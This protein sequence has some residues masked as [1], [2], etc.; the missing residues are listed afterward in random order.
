MENRPGNGS[1]TGKLP[2]NDHGNRFQ[3][4]LLFLSFIRAINKSCKFHLGTELA[5][6]GGKF[7]D[8]I[9]VKNYGQPNEKKSF[10][11]LQAK[12]KQDEK[13]NSIKA[14]DLLNDN[15]D[16]F[17]LTKYFH[18][19]RDNIITAKE[20]P[21]TQDTV[22]CVICT[23][24]DFD[25]EDI[26]NYGMKLVILSED[27]LN[28]LPREL[29]TFNP[30]ERSIVKED[31]VKP[32]D[33]SKVKEKYYKVANFFLQCATNPEYDPSKQQDVI[34]SYKKICDT[35]GANE[36]IID[37]DPT[38]DGKMKFS[39][40]FINNVLKGEAKELRTVIDRK[41]RNGS[42][43]QIGESWKQWKFPCNPIDF[44]QKMPKCYRLEPIRWLEMYYL[45][46]VLRDC[47][48]NQKKSLDQQGDALKYYQA[49]LVDEKVIDLNTKTFYQDFISG[50]KNLSEAAKELRSIFASRLL[51]D[52]IFTFENA[53]TFFTPIARKSQPIGNEYGFWYR[54]RNLRESLGQVYEI[55]CQQ[56]RPPRP[57]E[58]QKTLKGSTTETLD[59]LANVLC[60][61]SNNRERKL[62]NQDDNFKSYHAALVNEKVLDT[63]TKRFHKDFLNDIELSKEARKL[64]SMIISRLLQSWKFTFSD[65]STFKN[66]KNS[67]RESIAQKKLDDDVTEIERF[68][69]EK[70][71]FAA[72]T[73]NEE[74]LIT[75]LNDEVGKNSK[76]Q[77]HDTDFQLPYILCQ[78]V[79]WFKRT[80]NVWLTGEE[81]EKII[82]DKTEQKLDSIRTTALTMHY[83]DE[84]KAFLSFNNEEIKK[85]S[86]ELKT[87]L[88]DR[89]N[90]EKL[91]LVNIKSSSPIFTA[92][93][94]IQVIGCISTDDKLKYYKFD[95]SYLVTSSRR[96]LEG[97][98]KEWIKKTLLSPGNP[99]QLLIVVNDNDVP[100][101]LVGSGLESNA[102]FS[103]SNESESLKGKKVI[104]IGKEKT[105]LTLLLY[106][107]NITFEQWSEDAK[108][109][110]LSKTISFQ[111]SEVTVRD[112]IGD[113]QPNEILD[114]ESINQLLTT[115]GE[116]SMAIPPYVTSKFEKSLYIKRK[117]TF[118]FDFNN[119]F[120]KEMAEDLNG[121][122]TAKKKKQCQINR[123]TGTI[124]WI[125][126]VNEEVKDE[127]WRNILKKRNEKREPLSE[128]N[129]INEENWETRAVIIKGVAGTGKSTVLFHFYDE[130]KKK[131]PN[132]WAIRIDLKDHFDALK[133][134][135]THS[136]NLSDA[137][138]FFLHLPNVVDN[139]SPFARSLLRRRLETGDRIVLMLDG[140]DEIDSDCK[141]IAIQLMKALIGNRKKE[142][143][144]LRL[145]I[146]TRPDVADNLQLQLG[147]LAYTLVNFSAENQT[148]YLTSFWTKNVVPINIQENE[149]I[150][151]IAKLLV[152]R[153]SEDL[154]DDEK[155]FI[156][157]PLQ[158]RIVAECF[159]QQVKTNIDDMRKGIE[160]QIT[161][162][163]I[164]SSWI[165]KKFDLAS[166]YRKL[167]EAKR[168]VFRKEKV[169][170]ESMNHIVEDSIELTIK[171]LE[172]RLAELAIQVIMTNNQNQLEIF[173]P[174]QSV[175]QSEADSRK[176]VDKLDEL[177]IRFGLVGPT[178]DKESFK[179]HFLHLTYAEYLM[180]E[181]LNKGFHT[182]EDQHN[183]LL[184]EEPVRQLIANEILVKYQ[185]EGVRVFLDSMLKE[186]VDTE[187][188]RR[189]HKLRKPG[190]NQ[191]ITNNLPDQLTNF[192]K[193]IQP[194]VY[195]HVINEIRNSNLFVFIFDCLQST[196]N[197]NKIQDIVELAFGENF[198]FDKYYEQSSRVFE[199]LIKYYEVENED[200]VKF[201]LEKMLRHTKTL[202]CVDGNSNATE[203]RN[204]LKL[205][206]D[207]MS[208]AK[209]K[210]KLNKFLDPEK[211]KEAEYLDAQL[212]HFLI[213]QDN[214]ESLLEHYLTLFSKIYPEKDAV[215]LN[216]LEQAFDY[217]GNT[218][219]L[220][221]DSEDKKE[222][223][224]EWFIGKIKKLLDIF[225]TLKREKVLEKMF[226]LVLKKD[227]EA[228]EAFYGPQ[229]RNETIR[230]A[231]ASLSE[232]DAGRMTHLHRAIY[233][234]QSEDVDEIL[235]WVV[236]N[237]N[238]PE[239]FEKII[240]N[241]VAR[242]DYAFTPFYVAFARG[243]KELCG[244][245]MKFLKQV[246]TTDELEKHLTD[247]KG[248][249]HRALLEA[250]IYEETD[251]V[252]MILQNIKDIFGQ[253]HFRFLLES[254]NC[255]HEYL[256][257]I[258]LQKKTYE[259][260]EKIIWPGREK[261]IKD[262]DFN[263]LVKLFFLNENYQE[264]MLQFV[265][266]KTPQE[267]I[268]Q[269]LQQI[270]ET[271]Y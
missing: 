183:K 77:L 68:F 117:M 152:E 27:Q 30:I 49:A 103:P 205:V 225:R 197:R 96:L 142:A 136:T 138:E 114:L 219:V 124:K 34:Q 151:E 185:Y 254:D 204:V 249:L 224:R 84:L 6:Y 192:A 128:D 69:N 143:K 86:D 35:L 101:Q 154:K 202:R 13:K 70:L 116:E 258:S 209:D 126:G 247:K 179:L 31:K 14:G 61:C 270:C 233:F 261:N 7:D 246:L 250:I 184:K 248:F 265:S 94:V 53:D 21:Q 81:G 74:E 268:E 78:M 113:G 236:G 213:C 178:A 198:S 97:R 132:I 172:F 175:Y 243:H 73:P 168:E 239:V 118:D 267:T 23:N 16:K 164:I 90:S 159:L 51:K 50:N 144:P 11:Y 41:V 150:E 195:T 131:D 91:Q 251:M 79:D 109:Y 181:Y 121:G 62:D 269:R 80:E 107:D 190:D 2:D 130:I 24:I 4:K 147:Q 173:W 33:E 60:E 230:M 110:L 216:L 146:T 125:Q 38:E 228:F 25:K 140:F 92:V 100:F 186:I 157:V 42:W 59:F 149:R 26:A 156:G 57:I 223:Y 217:Y 82:L 63:Q 252:E 106:E 56:F 170:A 238:I 235:Q 231:L 199:R 182:E 177:A 40:D 104:V 55:I 102:L 201:I 260:I 245:I 148:Q 134:Y 180:A 158:C 9:F 43:E 174:P 119:K 162:S 37:E 259:T 207:F 133:K 135:E 189:I 220:F 271:S 221:Y 5:S 32:V 211:E 266:N 194:S 108:D 256:R 52:C 208:E 196:S 3:S 232:R 93:K 129:L 112:L 137:I 12:H 15:N 163:D 171:Q 66:P 139:Q 229:E 214:C 105:D 215:L 71:I 237:K 39:K 95:D 244:K 176:H 65:S 145:Y 87:F 99:H 111:G 226:S 165:D 115:G 210:G 1:V 22:D 17:S 48:N 98:E 264:D 44:C 167:M 191:E 89:S 188:W 64:K 187:E 46:N 122:T 227:P 29:L 161:A 203:W 253:D 85:R 222:R 166:M 255:Q 212:L 263:D 160:N 18:S 218:F 193:T 45:A 234:N 10:L 54:V 241:C 123:E 240:V 262:E 200:K 8:L 242:D 76:I 83:K 28:D 75:I 206:L 169:V 155:S 120:W 20:G 88:M 58:T 47:A 36:K 19:Y 127:I 67:Q 72:N 257:F 141:K 153:V